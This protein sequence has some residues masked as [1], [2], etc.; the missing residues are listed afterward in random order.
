MYFVHFISGSGFNTQTTA[1]YTAL[2]V[3][4]SGWHAVRDAHGHTVSGLR[5]ARWVGHS[6]DD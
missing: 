5:Y 4:L 2:M 3:A 1:S 6:I